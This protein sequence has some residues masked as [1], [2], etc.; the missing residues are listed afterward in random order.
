VLFKKNEILKEAPVQKA[1]TTELTPNGERFTV[2]GK[3]ADI[4]TAID[5]L[6]PNHS[7]H[8]CTEGRWSSHELLARLLHLAG[9]SEVCITSWA[10]TEDPIRMLVNMIEDGL[11][12]DVHLVTDVR[13]KVNSP[14]AYQLAK[15]NF[16]YA[17]CKHPCEG[18]HN[19]Q[20]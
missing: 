6:K 5:Q 15:A 8:Y 12:T 10:L 17:T 3:K 19:N 9:P 13:I 4:L 1:L 11:I 2:M 20:P 7:L 16:Q 18:V 14:N